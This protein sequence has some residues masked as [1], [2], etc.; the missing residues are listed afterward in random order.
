MAISWQLQALRGCYRV[1]VTALFREIALRG[2]YGTYLREGVTAAKAEY[3]A[4][5][6]TLI[7]IDC[8]H[9]IHVQCRSNEH[10]DFT[11]ELLLNFHF[12][13]AFRMEGINCNLEFRMNRPKVRICVCFDFELGYQSSLTT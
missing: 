5:F 2:N 1:Y 11:I 4:H 12:K 6:S 13:S 8:I 7:Y 9:E 10:D 3:L